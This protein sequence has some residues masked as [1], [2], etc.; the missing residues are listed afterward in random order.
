M[1]RATPIPYM[2][3]AMGYVFPGRI[4]SAGI[5][6][7]TNTAN[8]RSTYAVSSLA[9]SWFSGAAS[10]PFVPNFVVFS[11]GIDYT[12][13]GIDYTSN[14]SS[15]TSTW[16]QRVVV[17]EIDDAM[18]AWMTRQP[19]ILSQV[20]NIMSCS[21]VAA[22]GAPRL[23]I[24][25]SF[26]TSSSAVTSTTNAIYFNTATT[27]SAV[28]ASKTLPSVTS[29]Q[30]QTTNVPSPTTVEVS[31]EKPSDEP[32]Q[33]A[34]SQEAGASSVA[35]ASS[36]DQPTRSTAVQG[37]GASSDQSA[38]ASTAGAPSDGPSQQSAQSAVTQD[39]G[40][41]SAAPA[42]KPSN[43][44]TQPAISQGAS[45][46]ALSIGSGVHPDQA[47]TVQDGNQRGSS[48]A[49]SN[50]RV[51]Q[52]SVPAVVVIGSATA[53]VLS[54][55][56]NPAAITI[57]STGGHVV[58][59]SAS[60][61][62]AQAP[63]TVVASSSQP[64]SAA[65]AYAIGSQTLKPGGPAIEVSGTTY[66]LQESGDVVVNGNT[67]PISTVAPQ[68]SAPAVPVVIGEVAATPVASDKY[69]IAG[70]TLNRGGP[71]VEISGTTY[72]LPTS[73]SNAI[74]NGQAAAIS[75]IQAPVGSPATV[76]IGG[77]TAKPESSGAYYLVADQTLNPGGSAI[78]VSGVTYSLPTSGANIVINGATSVMG[79]SDNPT[80][81]AVVFGSATA[82]PLVGGGYVVGSQVVNP[83]GSA[84]EISGTVYSLPASGSSVVINGEAT[85]IQVIASN[86]AVLTLGSQTYT[87]VAE[88]AIPLVVA[89]QTLI[90]GGSDITVSGTVFSLPPDAT[91]NIVVNG[92]T[93]SLTTGASGGVGLSLDSQELSF[94]PLSSGIIVA[95]QTLYPGGSAIVV[96]G[97]TISIPVGG[98]AVVIQSGTSTTTKGLG[99]YVWQ[100]IASTTSSSAFHPTSGVESSSS[101]ARLLGSSTHVGVDSSVA[102]VS[103]GTESASMASSA[104]TSTSD[105]SGQ[106]P[107][108]SFKPATMALVVCIFVIV[109]W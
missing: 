34:G 78:Q 29:T 74:I 55:D 43:N 60:T 87:A 48:Q 3:F 42:D 104:Q 14:V 85:A 92:Q 84:V 1:H 38:P 61:R 105:A 46:V 4:N 18:F 16:T 89:S 68:S 109:L 31:A 57:P 47:S 79:Q 26:L 7:G 88:S 30:A 91:G 106:Q 28:P 35:S 64:T 12:S 95:S 58:D 19:S 96:Q 67:M 99:G 41:P 37:E 39:A 107:T 98:T 94:T 103:T 56:A 59:I 25:V 51:V 45:S 24:R 32:A 62:L 36:G 50:T 101:T 69:V 75:S 21:P 22:A 2:A 49:D 65:S 63:S 27:T 86:N 53:M 66:S 93:T 90:P 83:G 76:V 73:A 20:P 77:V 6:I 72:S 54:P 5:C 15:Q 82:V 9:S 97:E 8:H 17:T 52:S 40:V 11:D 44:P 23:H 81:S 102:A 108:S 100:G 70:Q 33:P 80:V 71:A 13:F 10:V